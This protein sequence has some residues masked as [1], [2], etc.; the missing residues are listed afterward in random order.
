MNIIS[1]YTVIRF[2]LHGLLVSQLLGHIHTLSQIIV[3]TYLI[4]CIVIIVNL[5][6]YTVLSSFIRLADYLIVSTMHMLAV[7]SINT[8]LDIFSRQIK[9]TPVLSN[10][11]DKVQVSKPFWY[12]SGINLLFY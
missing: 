3:S 1:I 4:F 12:S 5:K 7:N 2:I 9:N 8:L 6:V 11:A 10:L